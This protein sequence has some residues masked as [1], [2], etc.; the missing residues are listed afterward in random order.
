MEYHPGHLVVYSAMLGIKKRDLK[1]L[2]MGK[3]A[4]EYKYRMGAKDRYLIGVQAIRGKMALAKRLADVPGLKQLA[5][6]SGL[7][8]KALKSI[9]E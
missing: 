7:R 1:L 6:R 3:G 5:A 9:Y 8:D 4:E 2:D